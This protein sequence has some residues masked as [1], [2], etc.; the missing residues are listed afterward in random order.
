MKKF[1]FA[2]VA[3][4]SFN[5][6]TSFAIVR[7]GWER[8]ILKAEMVELD[9]TGHEI[10]QPG[11]ITLTM[12][13]RDGAPAPTSFTL[14]EKRKVFCVRAPC[15]PITSKVQFKIVDKKPAG[16]GSFEYT[17]RDKNALLAGIRPLPVTTLKVVD[18]TTRLCDDYKKYMWEAK[19]QTTSPTARYRQRSLFG[20]PEPVYTIQ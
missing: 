14:V 9:E 13:Q 1:M 8:P 19:V 17:A 18:H 3:V 2:L 5:S 15:P 11:D 7:P 12:N 6:A 20:N 4:A 16:C 10:S